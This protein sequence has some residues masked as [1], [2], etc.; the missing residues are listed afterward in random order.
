M[1]K[2]NNQ[3]GFS[4]I[5]LTIA[6]TVTLVILAATMAL[7]SNAFG[8]RARESRKTDALTTARAALNVISREV[9]NSGYGLSSNGIVIGDSNAKRVHFRGNL[10]N[11]NSTTNSPAKT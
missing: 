6:M 8:I 10:N 11:N 4:L 3:K 7:F 9:A 1:K 5:E 2:E